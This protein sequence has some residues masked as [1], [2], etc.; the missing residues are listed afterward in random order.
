[1]KTNLYK[2]VVPA[3]YFLPI[4]CLIIISIIGIVVLSVGLITKQFP[5]IIVSILPLL[6]SLLWFGYYKHRINKESKEWLAYKSHT[7]NIG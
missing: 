7:K 6:T 5:L 2:F 1:M 3:E 4:I